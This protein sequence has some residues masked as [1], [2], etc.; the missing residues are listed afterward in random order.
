[1][2]KVLRYLQTEAWERAAKLQLTPA[3]KQ[4]VERLL[5]DYIT[6]LLERQLKSVDF[7]RRLRRGG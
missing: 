4:Q 5:L 1:M 2:L 6:F 3:T 7:L